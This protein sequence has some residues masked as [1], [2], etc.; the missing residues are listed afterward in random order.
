M[1]TEPNTPPTTTLNWTRSGK[2]LICELHGRAIR[3]ARSGREWVIYVN[4]SEY[5]CS[6]TR[7]AAQRFVERAL[8]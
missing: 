6:T 4:G 5:S 1:K 8:G 2:D 7:A 3:I